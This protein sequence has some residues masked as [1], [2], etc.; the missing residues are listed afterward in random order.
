MTDNNEFAPNRAP[1]EWHERD[2]FAAHALGGILAKCSTPTMPQGTR[3]AL[4]RLA[5]QMADELL[6]ERERERLH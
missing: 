6:V 5:Y 3:Q 2:T 4:A 1:R